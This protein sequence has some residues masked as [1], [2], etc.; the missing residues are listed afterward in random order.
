[1][2]DTLVVDELVASWRNGDG[3]DNPAG[4]LFASG[5]FAEAD[6]AIAEPCTTV[7]G[8]NCTGSGIYYCC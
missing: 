2:K 5:V 7:C 6:I 1:M 8:T 4:P 3:Q